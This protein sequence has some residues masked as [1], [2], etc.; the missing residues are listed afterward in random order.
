MSATTERRLSAIML[1]DIAGFSSLMEK[2]ESG[3][4][5][6]VRV[7]REQL[8]TPRVA[9]HGGRIIKTT[10]DGFL[11]EF[12]SATSAL[13]CGVEIQRAN[14]AQEESRPEDERIHMRIG[15]NVGDIIIDGDD[16]AGDGVI[17]AARLEPLSPLDGIC[18]SGT[19]REHIRQDL[20]IEYLDLGD[21][22]VKN[23]SR[24]I[25]AYQVNLTGKEGL[26]VK[27]VK[28]GKKKATLRTAIA[29][30]AGVALVLAGSSWYWHASRN[31]EVSPSTSA[32]DTPA[33]QRSA[34]SIMV[35]PF[36]NGTGDPQQGYIA[37]GLTASLT[38][39]LSRIR[40]AFVVAAATAFTYKDKA[41]TLQ[42]VGKDLGVRFVLQ[43]SVQRNGDKIRINAQLADT[44]SNAQLWSESFEG[45]QSDLFALQ[46]R[47]TTRIGNSIGREMVIVAARESETRKSSPKVSDLMLRARALGLK[48][49]SLETFQQIEASYRQVLAL[50]PNNAG[51]MGGLASILVLQAGNFGSAMDERV[52]ETKYVEGRDFALKARELDPDNPGTY[53]AIGYYARFH[54]DYTGYLRAAET[55]VALEPKSATAHNNLAA[56]FLH[57]GEPKRAIEH[58]TQAIDLDPKRPVDVTLLN[59]GRAYFMLGD[60]DAAIEW[61]QKSLAVNPT[62]PTTYAFLA[63]AYALKGDDAKARAAVADLRRVDPNFRLTEVQKP[64]PS[65]PAAYKEFWARKL[66]PA[67]RKAGLPE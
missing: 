36:A 20:G 46:D 2:D 12:P 24:P 4:F 14:H 56:S 59:M 26:K 48:P 25:R 47:V 19:V 50:E 3:T 9:E 35:L 23:I 33:T 58:L 65:S 61:Y 51:A 15:L 6:R 27:P 5:D 21:Q 67:L 37:D 39:D 53:T 52:K 41:V 55:R 57:G 8:I 49:Q 60:N 42:Q 32:N 16:I 54:D 66:I 18:V 43:G 29:G 30:L 64:Q 31:A 1:A 40:D 28:R 11:A 34:L 44:N 45:D 13:R 22:Q 7:L 10:G 63:M 62:F 38:A 17:I